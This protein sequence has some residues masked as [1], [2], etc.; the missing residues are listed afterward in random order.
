M[1]LNQVGLFL[2][3]G[4]LRVLWRFFVFGHLRVDHHRIRHMYL[5]CFII[6]VRNRKLLP[7][8]KPIIPPYHSPSNSQTTNSPESKSQTKQA[9]AQHTQSA[10]STTSN[11]IPSNHT[12]QVLPFPH[13][14]HKISLQVV[15]L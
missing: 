1:L 2:V 15:K 14:D 6:A 11:P 5:V 8:S 9:T 13:L 10:P 3:F 7:S 12:H 4:G